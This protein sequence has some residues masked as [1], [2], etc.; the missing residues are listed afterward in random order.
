[1]DRVKSIAGVDAHRSTPSHADASPIERLRCEIVQYL[2]TYELNQPAI[3]RFRGAGSMD[4]KSTFQ[5]FRSLERIQIDKL[6]I[7]YMLTFLK[8]IPYEQEIQADAANPFEQ[9][10]SFVRYRVNLLDEPDVQEAIQRKKGTDRI[11]RK[12]EYLHESISD[13]IAES[14]KPSPMNYKRLFSILLA[15]SNLWFSIHHHRWENYRKIDVYIYRLSIHL[16]IKAAVEGNS[17]R[18]SR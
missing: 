4:A 16:M 14:T 5:F 8:K 15:L 1:M 18:P 12:I 13:S 2:A 10:K 6:I 7:Q 11:Q 3:L 17:T 9:F